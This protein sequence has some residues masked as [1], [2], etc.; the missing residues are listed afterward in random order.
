MLDFGK[1]SFKDLVFARGEFLR[2]FSDQNEFLRLI[3]IYYMFKYMF[4]NKTTLLESNRSQK[5]T[6][7][8]S[9]W[10]KLVIRT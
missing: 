9:I 1:T 2:F 10:A 6:V 5:K 8:G 3:I 4:G 7:N